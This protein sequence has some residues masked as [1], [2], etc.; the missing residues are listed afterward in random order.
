MS[1]KTI[2][3]LGNAY[4]GKS[5]IIHRYLHGREEQQDY[6]PTIEDVWIKEIETQGKK[7]TLRVV[8]VGGE[9]EALK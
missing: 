1:A 8:E 2:C 9:G 5:S 7:M 3:F 4:S 6:I